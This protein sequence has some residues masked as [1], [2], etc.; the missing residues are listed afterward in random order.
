MEAGHASWMNMEL[1]L[2]SEIPPLPLG[3][4][5]NCRGSRFSAE[6]LRFTPVI[7]PDDRRNFR[8]IS[9]SCLTRP[10]CNTLHNPRSTRVQVGISDSSWIDVSFAVVSK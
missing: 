2:L 4:S 1:E 10:R 8:F 9:L 3:S 5:D 7:I 6:G